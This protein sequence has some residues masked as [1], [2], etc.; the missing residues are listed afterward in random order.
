MGRQAV[1][2]VEASTSAFNEARAAICA[3][4]ELRKLP[5][6]IAEVEKSQAT[7]SAVPAVP[8]FQSFE[9]SE[10][11][12]AIPK[13]IAT[14]GSLIDP[15]SLPGAI[16]SHA[17]LHTINTF[18]S[19]ALEHSR[20]LS[21][22]AAALDT[23]EILHQKL[24]EMQEHYQRL[25]LKE[26]GFASAQEA[27]RALA[28]KEAERS[29]LTRRWLVLNRDRKLAPVKARIA[30][31]AKLPGNR[32][33]YDPLAD[34]GWP[35]IDYS[36]SCLAELRRDTQQTI[37]N[38]LRNASQLVAQIVRDDV[39]RYGYQALRLQLADA[40]TEQLYEHDF[41][42]ACRAKLGAYPDETFYNGVR[43][44]NL[45]SHPDILAAKKLIQ[46]EVGLKAQGNMWGTSPEIQEL[47][48][49]LPY[50]L[51]ELV[52]PAYQQK[53]IESYLDAILLRSICGASSIDAGVVARGLDSAHARRSDN[54]SDG[55]EFVPHLWQIAAELAT[56]ELNIPTHDVVAAKA[57]IKNV[58]LRAALT[59]APHTDE[60]NRAGRALFNLADPELTPLMVI[61]AYREPGYSGESPFLAGKGKS[62]KIYHFLSSLSDQERTA[63]SK[64][65]IPGLDRAIALILSNPNDFNTY[66]LET[67]QG[68]EHNPIDQQI[69]S[70]LSS[71]CLHYLKLGTPQEQYFV[72]GA[73]ERSG[74]ITPEANSA[75]RKL[76]GATNSQDLRDEILGLI[77]SKPDAF[78]PL[79]QEVLADLADKNSHLCREISPHKLHTVAA[80]L[81]GALLRSPL[82]PESA[83][84]LGTI[85][86]TSGDHIERLHQ[87]LT[88]SLASRDY[89]GQIN[90]PFSRGSRYDNPLPE[91]EALLEA[92]K[93]VDATQKI[94]TLV[95]AGYKYSEQSAWALPLV[96][97]NFESIMP[98]LKLLSALGIS[99]YSPVGVDQSKPES[100][101]TSPIGCYLLGLSVP[102]R[103]AFL[104]KAREH[105]DGR[106]DPLITR[107]F[108]TC[109]LRPTTGQDAFDKIA[110]DFSVF[111]GACAV[112]A[113]SNRSYVSLMSTGAALLQQRFDSRE[114][115]QI[116]PKLDLMERRV[117]TATSTLLREVAQIWP[118][119]AQN[120]AGV[121]AIIDGL[122]PL[123]GRAINDGDDIRQFGQL[124]EMRR[125]LL[126]SSAEPS[127]EI[128]EAGKFVEQFGPR[129]LPEVFA[130]WLAL[131]RGEPP[132][133]SLRQCGITAT[134][135]EGQRL[136][137]G[138]V[139]TVFRTLVTRD[140]TVDVNSSIDVEILSLIVRFNISQWHQ[141]ASLRD[142]VQNYN[143]DRARGLIA[144]TP[145]FLTT[146]RMQVRKLD[147]VSVTGFVFSDP[148]QKRFAQLQ[149][150]LSFAV[151]MPIERLISSEITPL[152]GSLRTREAELCQPL[153]AEDAARDKGGKRAENRAR[154]AQEFKECASTLEKTL[155]GTEK[156]ATPELIRTLAEFDKDDHPATTTALRRII[157]AYA[158]HQATHSAHLERLTQASLSPD[159]LGQLAEVIQDIVLKQGIPAIGLDPKSRGSKRAREIFGTK[160]LTEELTRLQSFGSR[161]S[162]EWHLIPNRGLITE[163]TANICDAC[164]ARNQNLARG[165]ANFTPVIFA[166]DPDSPDGKLLGACFLIDAINA[167]GER[168]LIIRGNNPQQNHITRVSAESFFESFVE[169]LAPQAKAAGFSEILIPMDGCGGS[170]TNRPPLSLYLRATYGTAPRVEL[171]TDRPTTFN[172]YDIRNKCVRV[173]Q[174]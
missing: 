131:E 150:D 68:Y 90:I 115:V 164:W 94:A 103:A 14:L 70:C 92:S 12:L 2:P 114:L 156:L 104:E 97:A 51:S 65:E 143:R 6:K 98:E 71:L 141:P 63:L 53:H 57:E 11:F 146:G 153:S 137:Q 16:Q 20:S 159:S 3:L 158:T 165:H 27:S 83:E 45:T 23:L 84:H 170:Q 122:S 130:G 34:I 19:A 127:K 129:Y 117:G 64:R 162:E 125:K 35:A 133:E 135:R 41:L 21:I 95:G 80:G 140:G 18:S 119:H 56:K 121:E 174:L 155:N 39:A 5:A 144:P 4:E 110:A 88:E 173:R 85:F 123:L 161:D 78:A 93:D 1:A 55:T 66:M 77:I 108:L 46:L 138:H 67:A 22:A 69:R 116:L 42:P 142:I 59:S 79:T 105:G 86:G 58:A 111:E 147:A 101:L 73:L 13:L 128:A 91:F 61:L 160:S 15:P 47:R 81:Y 49:T 28:D 40:L 8:D 136:L 9:R 33:F 44:D 76:L 168:V 50:W 149:S 154:R 54:S 26:A 29:S 87:V 124:I 89:R 38:S 107:G 112:H 30:E 62:S 152:L 96:V 60:S 166:K 171:G 134:G 82:A 52:A 139:D 151:G 75:L 113:S 17:N 74:P 126:Q 31:L 172:D 100:A 72:L 37:Q 118:M 169:W 102:A 36:K 109:A 120:A 10:Q 32:D 145:E 99:N 25:V 148:C 24:P 157:M 163:F 167:Q 106:M 132:T 48:Q 7:I 43:Q